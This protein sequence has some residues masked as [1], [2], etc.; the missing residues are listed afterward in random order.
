MRECLCLGDMVCNS[1]FYSLPN[2]D[3]CDL[4]WVRAKY[5]LL[6]WAN[7]SHLIY[8]QQICCKRGHIENILELTMLDFNGTYSYYWDLRV[9]T[10]MNSRPWCGIESGE[11]FLGRNHVV[12]C[13]IIYKVILQ[14]SE[15]R[16]QGMTTLMTFYQFS[17]I[18]LL[19]SLWKDN[20]V[21]STT[22]ALK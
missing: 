21:E 14:Q 4:Y 10:H 7:V 17:I 2:W 9:I 1:F 20:I 8:R 13:S 3:L 22:G 19:Y 5:H 6:W 11:G 15:A 18:R 16:L 12:G